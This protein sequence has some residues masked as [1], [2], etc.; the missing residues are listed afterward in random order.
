MGGSTPTEFIEGTDQTGAEL[1]QFMHTAQGDP[2][3]LLADRQRCLR[4]KEASR[5]VV[6]GDLSC[7]SSVI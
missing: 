7:S 2:T 6:R 3:K 1:N 4:I 5:S